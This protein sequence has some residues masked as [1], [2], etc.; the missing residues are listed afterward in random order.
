MCPLGSV[1]Y[2]G[3]VCKLVVNGADLVE[4]A[5]AHKS[6]QALNVIKKFHAQSAEHEN[7]HAH[8]C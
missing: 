8:K 7:F 1:F 6:S 5:L 3:K 2:C 4:T